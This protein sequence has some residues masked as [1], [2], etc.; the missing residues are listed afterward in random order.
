[1]GVVKL[2]DELWL[3]TK[4]QSN[5]EI[6]RSLRNIFKYSATSNLNTGKALFDRGGVMSYQDQVN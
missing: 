3:G 4:D 5:C 2:S 6:A 1:V